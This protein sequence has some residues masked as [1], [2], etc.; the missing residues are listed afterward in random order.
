MH[1]IHIILV[2]MRATYGLIS[3]R[4]I[5]AAMIMLGSILMTCTSLISDKTVHQSEYVTGPEKTGLIYI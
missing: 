4:L 2:T 3:K 1:P 5:M